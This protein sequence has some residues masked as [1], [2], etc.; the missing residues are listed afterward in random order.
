LQRSA[1][2]QFHH[3]VIGTNIVKLANVRVVE[4]SGRVR[5]PFESFGEPRGRNFDRHLAI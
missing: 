1:V 3:Q 4:R 5:L 2:D